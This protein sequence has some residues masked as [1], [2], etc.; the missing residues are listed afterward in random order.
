MQLQHEYSLITRMRAII[1][2]KA[3][4]V[5]GYRLQWI[6]MKKRSRPLEHT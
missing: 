5:L 2:Y 3:T 6:E 4:V 1:R